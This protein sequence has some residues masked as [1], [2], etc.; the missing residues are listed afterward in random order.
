MGFGLRCRTGR[1]VPNRKSGVNKELMHANTRYIL[2][3]LIYVVETPN[4]V[5]TKVV[6]VSPFRGRSRTGPIVPTHLPSV[7]EREEKECL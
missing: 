3:M 1:F 5:Q 2:D 6:V 4:P 7:T